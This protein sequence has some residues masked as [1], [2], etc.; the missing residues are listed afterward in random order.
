MKRD[1]PYLH[2][3]SIVQ[4][5]SWAREKCEETASLISLQLILL[6]KKYPLPSK[7]GQ[8]VRRGAV[9]SSV[10]KRGPLREKFTLIYRNSLAV[11]LSTV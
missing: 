5:P 4:K 8:M 6:H 1:F 9:S 2:I 11:I 10:R 7:Q 3:F